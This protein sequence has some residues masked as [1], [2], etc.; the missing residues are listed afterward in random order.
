[1][2]KK[3]PKQLFVRIEI[4]PNDKDMSWFSASDTVEGVMSNNDGPEAVGFYKLMETK[5]VEKVIHV[6]GAAKSRK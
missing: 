1:M 3:L 2:P 5:R 4:D 6:A